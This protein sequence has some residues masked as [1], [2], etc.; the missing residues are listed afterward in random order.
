MQS[1]A[2][3]AEAQPTTRSSRWRIWGTL[4]KLVIGVTL[5]A[6][7]LIFGRI[8]FGALAGLVDA[9]WTVALAVLLLV[10]TIPLAALRWGLVLRAFALPISLKP[11]VHFVAMATI[12]NALLLGPAG[13]DAVRGVYAWRALERGTGRITAS[14]L[15]DR[16]FGLVGLTSLALA[17][18]LWHWDWMRRVPALH[19]LGTSLFVA[20]AACAVGG[21]LLLMAPRLT[22]F[23]AARLARWPRSRSRWLFMSPISVRCCCWLGL[24]RSVF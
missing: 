12:S 15:V 19:A 18:T 13:G 23:L 17:F 24:S 4:L 5:L 22:L 20:F 14:I 6:L 11:L 8:D 2:P 1:T 10:S 16:I 3:A 7:L 21:C 9:P